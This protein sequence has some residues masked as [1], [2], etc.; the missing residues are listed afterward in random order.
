MSKPEL[1]QLV[2]ALKTKGF[3]GHL[4]SWRALNGQGRTYN[5]SAKAPTPVSDHALCPKQLAKAVK[6]NAGLGWGEDQAKDFIKNADLGGDGKLGFQS[7]SRIWTEAKGLR[8]KTPTPEPKKRPTSASPYLSPARPGVKAST[9]QRP[10]SAQKGKVPAL[11]VKHLEVEKKGQNPKTAKVEEKE[12]EVEEWLELELK[13][14]IGLD[15]VKAQMRSFL[16][17][18]RLERRRKELGVPLGSEAEGYDMVFYGNPGTG[19]TS[20]ARLV[21]KLLQKLGVLKKSAPF[22]ELGRGDLVGAYIGA[23]EQNCA[24]KIEEA[25]GGIIFIDEAYTLT[26]GGGSDGRDFGLKALEIIMQCMTSNEKDRP[27]FIFAGYKLQME[28][29]L[30]AN[31]GMARRVA[32]K[33]HFEDYNPNQLAQIS[34]NKAKGR[35]LELT[36]EA[37]AQLPKIFSE[38]FSVQAM[39]LWN[40]GLASR[41]VSDSV[42]V[43]NDRLDPSSASKSDLCT[44]TLQDLEL[45]ARLSSDA[46]NA[47][48]SIIDADQGAEGAGEVEGVESARDKVVGSRSGA[49]SEVPRGQGPA[50]VGTLAASTSISTMHLKVAWVRG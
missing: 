26:P 31:P 7:W 30:Q 8:A 37:Q 42:Q 2:L 47:L 27:I 24:K 45:G 39:S 20:V 16:K 48:N 12:L 11:N 50:E 9:P 29:F 49:G 23:T 35:G 38:H 15:K 19:K 41:L 33:F 5:N 4:Q 46:V 13:Q 21:P 40:G 17:S 1:D 36:A 32:Y 10:T 14:V 18:L 25:K 3:S 43:L 6:D 22:L 44:L 34:L 28:S